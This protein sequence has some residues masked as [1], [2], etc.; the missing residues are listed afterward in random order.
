MAPHTTAV[1]KA[2]ICTMK[3][4]GSLNDAVCAALIDHHNLTN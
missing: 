1:E 2:I 3:K 4:L